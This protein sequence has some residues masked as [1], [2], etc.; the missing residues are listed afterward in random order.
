MTEA[1]G[2]RLRKALRTIDRRPRF[3]VSNG[4]CADKTG[5]VHIYD[6]EFR[7]VASLRVTGDFGDV[8]DKLR[9]AEAICAVLN[10]AGKKIPSE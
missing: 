10:A 6:D 9:F 8:K 5:R 2:T 1:K 3:S 4:G 7:W